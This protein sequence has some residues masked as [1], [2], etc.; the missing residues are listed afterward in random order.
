M[1][2]RFDARGVQMK[3]A[4]DWQAYQLGGWTRLLHKAKPTFVGSEPVHVGGLG[5]W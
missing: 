4:A 3:S 2:Q 5:A 1:A